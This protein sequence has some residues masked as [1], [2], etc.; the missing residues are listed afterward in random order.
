MKRAKTTNVI[1]ALVITAMV[2]SVLVLPVMN[3]DYAVQ[4]AT[5]KVKVT[6]KAN[7]GKFT[8]K[9]Y[10]KKKSYSKKIKKNKKIGKLPKAKRTGYTLKGWYTKK[11][12]GKKVTKKTKM[13]K[14]TTLY[15]RWT[16]KSYTVSFNANGGTVSTASIKVKYNGTY[17]TLP[18]P[19]N[20]TKVFLGWFTAA[21]GGT[22]V[23]NT[24]KYK[25]AKNTTL[26]A[27]WSEL[28]V[29]SD[30]YKI[31]GLTTAQA[32]ALPEYAK[33]EKLA[34]DPVSNK[35]VAVEYKAN[36]VFNETFTAMSLADLN[37]KTSFTFEEIKELK[38]IAEVSVAK[39]GNYYYYVFSAD[40][41]VGPESRFV[42]SILPPLDMIPFWTTP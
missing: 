16:A 24:T 1:T 20:G 11:N 39:S 9:K 8:A 12:G 13:K 21:T 4:A 18:T 40:S 5:K 15:A 27:Q 35:V 30:P 19:K 3:D 26:Y 25:T 14:K 37:K 17:G 42:I 34:A 36:T 22:K 6:Y 2:A 32:M 41:K 33:V 7:G 29:I 23:D 28:S 38:G 31:I 10:A